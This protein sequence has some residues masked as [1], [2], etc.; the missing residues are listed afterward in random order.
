M[1]EGQI[2]EFDFYGHALVKGE[3]ISIDGDLIKFKVISDSKNIYSVGEIAESN[4][5]H[6][7]QKDNF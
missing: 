6:L 4:K 5:A 7:I 1:E 3:F 2:I